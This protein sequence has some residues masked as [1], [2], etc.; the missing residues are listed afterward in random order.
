MPKH[1]LMKSNPW[2]CL[3]AS[4]SFYSGSNMLPHKES[5]Q[6]TRAL[7]LNQRNASFI[8][9]QYSFYTYFACHFPLPIKQ[10]G[11]VPH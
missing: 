1:T 6:L 9:F 7:Y 2:C 10:K 5:V 8:P 4:F 3:K 11:K